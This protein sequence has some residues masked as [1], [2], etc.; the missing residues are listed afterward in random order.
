MLGIRVS[1]SPAF[2]DALLATSGHHS[3][4]SLDSSKFWIFPSRLGHEPMAASSSISEDAYRTPCGGGIFFF[5]DIPHYPHQPA[6]AA[7]PGSPRGKAASPLSCWADGTSPS[8]DNS[9]THRVTRAGTP[10]AEAKLPSSQ[11]VLKASRSGDH[12]VA[13]TSSDGPLPGP[14]C[15][16][17]RTTLS[18]KSYSCIYF[19]ATLRR[20]NTHIVLWSETQS[21]SLR[22]EGK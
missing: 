15:Q 6:A 1:P 14:R 7:F 11:G 3:Y 18:L 5:H 21:D 17:S 2:H 16:P 20:H 8:F 4:C 10:P 13:P 19:S 22:R 12:Q 9:A